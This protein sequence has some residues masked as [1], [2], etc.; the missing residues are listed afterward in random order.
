MIRSEFR[1]LCKVWVRTDGQPYV[2]S[3]TEWNTLINDGLAILSRKTLICYASN[4][5][6]NTGT[7]WL[8][9]TPP[10]YDLMDA[11]L[12]TVD[13]QGY[14]LKVFLPINVIIGDRPLRNLQDQVGK[15]SNNEMQSFDV[16]GTAE[17]STAAGVRHWTL[18]W[19]RK[20]RLLATPGAG[21]NTPS[22]ITGVLPGF[23]LHPALSN[24][25]HTLYIP[26]DYTRMASAFVASL[27]LDPRASGSSLEKMK[28]LDERSHGEFMELVTQ[29]GVIYQRELGFVP[30]EVKQ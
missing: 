12:Y 8:Y 23:Y 29:A 28:R 9:G 25:A 20:I 13:A 27:A 7:G 6:I 17:T 21:F 26:D 19:P 22:V 10:L 3:D 1:D 5:A 11:S 30:Q 14:A 15:I 18:E 24:N 4:I 2:S 16:Y